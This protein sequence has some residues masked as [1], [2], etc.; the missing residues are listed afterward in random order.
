MTATV[1]YLEHV[2]VP[3]KRRV[4]HVGRRT[5]QA[6][7]PE[8]RRPYIAMVNGEAVLRGEWDRVLRHGD[9]LAFVDVHALPQGGGGKSNPLHLI[10]TIAVMVYAPQLGMLAYESM[11]GA[12][13]VTSTGYT[14]AGAIGSAVGMALV[15]ALIP[16]PKPPTPH[17]AAQLAAP[18]PT[19]HLQ[20]QGNQAR[21]ESAIPEHFGRM[22]AYPDFAAQPYAEYAG[23]EQYLYQLFCLGRGEYDIEAIR[24]EDTPIN[25]FDDITYEVIP[26]NGALTLFP[27]NVVTSPEVSGQDLPCATGTYSQTGTTVTV[28]QTAHGLSVGRQVYL[29]F[30]SG[31]AADGTYSVASVPTANTFTVTHGT[32]QT[33]SGSVT[34]SPWLGGFVA[35]AASTQA[36]YLGIDLVAARGL[37]QFNSDG[38]LLEVS[39][40]VMV[41]ARAIDG[42]GLPL[43]PWTPI[44]TIT[45][46]GAT[47]TPKRRSDRYSVSAGRYEVRAR[48]TDVEQTGSDYGHDVA[49]AGLRAYLPDTR[50]FGDVTL[51]AMRLRASNNLSMQASRK[52]NVIATRKLPVWDGS[53]W[54]SPQPTRSIAWAAAYCA[55]QMGLTDAQIDLDGLRGLDAVWA[56]R[57]D[58]FDGRFD[59]FLSFWEALSKICVAGR[60]KPF[61]Q[62]GVVRVM[63]DQAETIP[64]ALFSMRNIVRGSFGVDYLM[65]TSDTADAVDVVYFDD[66]AMAPSR[67]RAK[68]PGSSASKP[69]KVEL[70]G[71]VKRDQAFREGLYQAA[72][73]R[74]RRRLITF[75]TEMDGFI[76]SFGDL[77]AVQHDM[78]AWGQHAEVVAVDGA[79]LTLS[80]PMTWTGWL[81]HYIGLRRRDGSLE[82]PIQVTPGADA[83]RVV[84]TGAPTFVPYTGQAEER[85]HVVFGWSETWR[86]L[87]RV[88]A[89]KPAGLYEVEIQ[90]VNEDAAVHTAETGQTAP[91]PSSSQLPGYVA[92]PTVAGLLVRSMPGAP[93]NMLMTWEAS[94][95][96]D[97]YLIEQSSDG[98]NWTRTG[99]TRTSNYT[100]TALYGSGTILRIAAVGMAKGPWVTVSYGASADY[101]WTTDGAAMWTADGNRMWRY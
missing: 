58:T 11:V 26:P 97:H 86:Q 10:A 45:L 60:A 9:V 44:G 95:W 4:R 83:Y 82:G 41:E 62:G 72:C 29:D 87:A 92:A 5:I 65:P 22:L 35:N 77:I 91:S 3:H 46:T 70:F 89:V 101:M 49:W 7:A 24:V 21:L 15:N 36:N 38:R 53:A 99:E 23:N 96:A 68:L 16:P 17:Q 66:A 84:M 88:L 2:L 73:N 33:T 67:V 100:A 32:S 81:P 48:R 51:L 64:V 37:Y 52:I 6:L 25:S 20:A 71:V 1:I 74:Y 69:A 59:N 42:A 61:M 40:T 19:Y 8:W 56:A 30:T 63:R 93:E 31:A 18:S 28:T 50:V 13:A 55:K 27:S 47:T 34:V 75:K 12:T 76:P 43:G 54:S 14:V 79:V 85:T 90:A 39:L 78:P 98:A 94:P 80:E 57:D